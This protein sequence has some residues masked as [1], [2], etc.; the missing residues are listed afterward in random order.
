MIEEIDQATLEA[1][2]AHIPWLPA[3]LKWARRRPAALRTPIPSAGDRVYYRHHEWR[4]VVDADVIGVQSLTD[5]DDP[6]LWRF[7]LDSAGVAVEVEGRLVMI[8][9]FDPWPLLTLK[10]PFGTGLSREARLRGSAGWLPLDWRTR[11][12]PVPRIRVV[13]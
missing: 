3:E 1:A 10:T 7:Q 13:T 6:N 11:Y 2:T 5:L 9:A 4:D 8:A 12:R